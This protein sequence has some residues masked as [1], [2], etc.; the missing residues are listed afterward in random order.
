MN[1]SIK[2]LNLI[3][4]LLLDPCRTHPDTSTPTPPR[5]RGVK[6]QKTHMQRSAKKEFSARGVESPFQV[7]WQSD[8]RCIP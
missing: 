8:G 1:Y 2:F 5:Y 6:R 3:F 4:M 7:A